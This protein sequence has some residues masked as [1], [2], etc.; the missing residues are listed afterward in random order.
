MREL[1]IS[2][3]SRMHASVW[4]LPEPWNKVS[5]ASTTSV[6]KRSYLN[7]TNDATVWRVCVDVN[8]FSI[9]HSQKPAGGEI[10]ETMLECGKFEKWCVDQ[11][12]LVRT[13]QAVV[14]FALKLVQ[15]R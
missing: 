6:T 2:A 8:A 15:E 13:E 9:A 14:A 7:A 11:L 12:M 1:E 5:T 10:I 4:L 3:F